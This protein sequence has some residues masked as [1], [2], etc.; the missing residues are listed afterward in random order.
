M[1]RQKSLRPAY[2]LHKH[3]GQAKVR[4]DGRDYYLGPYGS[5][6]SRHKYDDLLTEW[7]LRQ[8][9]GRVTLC[10]DDLALMYLDHARTYYR[11]NGRETS[12]VARIRSALQHLVTAHGRTRARSFGPMALK[13]VRQSM[14]EAGWCRKS[15]NDHVHRIR[16][17]F[18]WAAENEYVPATVFSALCTV[19]G[20]RKG[21]TEAPDRE[22]VQPVDDSVVDATCPYLPTPVAAM[23]RLQRLTG[24]R[25]G[26][27]CSMRPCD[28]TRGLDGVWSYRPA[29]HKTEHHGHDRRVFIGP[30]GQ[31]V[32]RPFLDRPADAYCFSPVEAE[33]ERNA[34]RRANRK[35]P[36]TPSQAARARNADRRRP[37]REHYTKD[38]FRRAVERAC[39]VAFGMPAELRCVERTIQRLRK[40]DPKV[41]VDVLHAER[42]RLKEAAAVW[43][44]KH[45]WSP[46]QIRHTVGTVIRREAGVEAARCVL[47]HSN[48]DATE[49]YAEAD[50]AKARDIIGRVG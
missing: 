14:I 41:S 40:T 6:E 46:N 5:Q 7:L 9:V 42:M 26:E 34:K 32:L 2:Q 29:S 21:R 24:M 48:L 22:P 20:L 18:K 10:C 33:A 12:E 47:G 49:I 44:D 28:V 17:V 31:E 43:R 1:P 35:S 38:S 45:V 13:R 11:K 50:L 39:E 27:V 37:W 16:R 4:I 8:D 36:M 23:V 3:S 19:S 15:V 25:P 30:K